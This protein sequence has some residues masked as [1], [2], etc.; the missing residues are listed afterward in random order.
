MPKIPEND[1]TNG[2]YTNGRVW[3]ELYE[4]HSLT[5]GYVQATTNA[6]RKEGWN[7]AAIMSRIDY[8]RRAIDVGLVKKKYIPIARISIENLEA[9]LYGEQ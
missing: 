7:G 4:P 2:D 1:Y 9:Q 6:S 3:N 5:V 8:M